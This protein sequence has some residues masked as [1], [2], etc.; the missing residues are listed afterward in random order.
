MKTVFFFAF[1]ENKIELS[2]ARQM[3]TLNNTE[4]S[5]NQHLQYLEYFS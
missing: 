2:I 5:K 4:I 3:A 1:H